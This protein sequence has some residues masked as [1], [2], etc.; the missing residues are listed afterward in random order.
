MPVIFAMRWSSMKGPFLAE[1]DIVL[2]SKFL[3]AMLDTTNLLRAR[4]GVSQKLLAAAVDDEHIGPLVVAGLISA[5][6]LAPWGYR[7]TSARGLTFTTTVRV[8]DR[9][10]RNTAVRRTNAL[11]AV[12]SGL[13]DRDILVVRVANLANRRHA[14]DEHLAGLARGQLQKSVIAFFGNQVDLCAGRTRHLCTL[15]RTQLDVVHDRTNR[16]VLQ[17]Q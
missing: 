14:L 5:G 2:S 15:T 10:H 17:R 12:A 4:L 16:N 13:T 9:V 11:P 8:I 6:R 3:V 1:R 7:V